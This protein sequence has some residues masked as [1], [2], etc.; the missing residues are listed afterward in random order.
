MCL[1]IPQAAFK[2]YTGVFDEDSLNI[3]RS[4]P[5]VSFIEPDYIANIS[6]TVSPF[7][8]SAQ[9]ARLRPRGSLWCTLLRICTPAPGGSETESDGTGVDIYGLG[10]CLLCSSS[11]PRFF[12][13]RENIPRIDHEPLTESVHQIPVSISS[14]RISEGELY[15]VPGSGGTTRAMMA[16][17][18]CDVFDLL[19]PLNLAPATVHIQRA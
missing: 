15:M 7:Q 6:Y 4:D 5:S 8:T 11:K 16:M 12:V 19:T 1:L 2:G 9:P 18:G 10:E 13:C 17:G 3:I 14:T